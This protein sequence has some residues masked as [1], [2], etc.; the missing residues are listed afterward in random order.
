MKRISLTQ[1][2]YALVDDE[3]FELASRFKWYV[4]RRGYVRTC[5]RL[6]HIGGKRKNAHV[7]LHRLIMRPPKDMQVDHKNHIKLDCRRENMRICTNRE[8]AHN[9]VIRKGTSSF[10]GVCWH[11]AKGKW[12]SRIRIDYKIIHLGRFVDEA[13][14]AC[15]YDTAARELF[16]EFALTNF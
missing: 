16:G 6:G 10:K 1:G 15:A 12:L 2:R 4:T 9:Q 3:D 8:N 13:D 11:K 7:L 14:A 5:V